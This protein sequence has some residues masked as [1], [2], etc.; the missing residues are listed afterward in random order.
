V[1]SVTAKYL[2]GYSG[3]LEDIFKIPKSKLLEIPG[4][5]EKTAESIINH[6]G[7]LQ[8]AEAEVAF[9]Q[10]HHIT[11]LFFFDTAYPQRLKKNNDAPMM[12]YF[13]GN[14]DL[15]AARIVSIVGTRKASDYGKELCNKLVA[16][17]VEHN[18]L[19]VS[20]LAYGIDQAAHQACVQ[21][22][23]A[24]VGVLAHGLDR[25][26][27]PEHEK[28]AKNML[29]NGGLLSE[30]TS[31]TKPDKT[32]F[33]QR[34]RIIA[35][36]S[37]ATIVVET[38]PKGGSIITALL[39]NSYQRDVFA[40]PGRTTDKYSTGCNLLI[41][42]NQAIL[43]ES[44]DDIANHLNWKADPKKPAHVQ[45][46]LF[47]ELEPDEEI[48]INALQNATSNG[49]HIDQ[50]SHQSQL[51]PSATATALLMLEFKGLVRALVGNVYKLS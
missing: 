38:A 32:N 29:E 18:A 8:R 45:K 6:S 40:F 22:K 19:V 13:K 24:T 46:Q 51:G 9:I 3:S 48:I 43:I 16:K 4:V 14:A 11:P 35:G 28:L 15:N 44:A 10:K 17:L 39:A 41:K 36:I 2:I 5:G 27:P 25:I 21:H 12:L 37:D 50:L 33:P 49:L 30:F 23:L 31:G 34:N 47:V 1:G 26:Y 7:V 42:S 20:G